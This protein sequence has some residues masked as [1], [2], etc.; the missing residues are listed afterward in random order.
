MRI[1]TNDQ[2]DD[3][4][5]IV[6]AIYEGA[7]D[8]GIARE[9]IHRLLGCANLGGFRPVGTGDD[10]RLVALYTTGENR[11]WPD[12]IDLNTGQFVYYGDNRTP[13]HELHDTPVGGNQILRRVFGLLHAELPERELIPPFF[14]FAKHPTIRSKRSVQFKGMAIPGHPAL[15]AR[16]DLVA[17][18]KT[19]RRQ[20]FQNYR[21][22]FTILNAPVIKRD[23]LLEL[24]AGNATGGASPPAWMQWV[25]TGRREPLTSEPTTV[26]RSNEEQ[27]PTSSTETDILRCVWEYFRPAPHA[28]EA[29]A[30]RVYQMLDS[31][32]TI[33]E[34]TR[35]VVDGGRDAVGRYR[36]GIASDPV[37]M[38]FSLEAK[39]YRPGIDGNAASTVGVKD[40]SRLISR[41]RHRQFGVLVT[42]STIA[43]QVYREVREDRHPIVFV[44]GK[45]IAQILIDNGHNTS[46][47]VRSLLTGE[48]PLS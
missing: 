5:L 27:R 12:R 10:K 18:W 2:L 35:G 14:V 13:G 43:R 39:C 17:E 9:P 32:V 8:G 30:A 48:F 11:D 3:A 16:Q 19:T 45:D 46:E 42:T 37:E 28:F 47:L 41:I 40:V 21:A 24:A 20:R 15:S 38:D 29:F 23:W 7:N 26:V 1:F 34:I 4:D 31:R 6:D 22:V 25:A 44:C 36:I 33:D